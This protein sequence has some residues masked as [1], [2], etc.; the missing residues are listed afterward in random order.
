M[1]NEFLSSAKKQFSQLSNE[2]LFWKLNEE[3][4]SIAIIVKHMAGNMQSRW[5]DLFSLG[6]S[7]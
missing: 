7:H 4:N 3:S 1:Q 2:Q 6:N 5:T